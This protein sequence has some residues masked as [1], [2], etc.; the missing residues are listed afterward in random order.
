MMSESVFEELDAR[1]RAAVR[2]GTHRVEAPAV[3]AGPR[4]GL[5]IILRPDPEAA[6][7]LAELANTA[8]DAAGRHHWCTG[9]AASSHITI[10]GLEP[11]RTDIPADDRAV[12]QYTRAIELAA[13][14]A[15]PITFTMGGLILT[16]ISIMVRAQ[17]R[18][19]HAGLLSAELAH[20]L[21]EAGWYEAVFTR[22]IWYLNLVH[23][24][25]PFVDPVSL[26]DWVA[27]RRD[28]DLGT[29]TS[30]AWISCDG[31]SVQAEPRFP[32]ASRQPP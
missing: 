13:P 32:S 8:I 3:D 31:I 12:A 22:T 20:A 16:P 24:A 7:R 26:I 29:T 4:W 11:H 15:R 10:R 18:A 30:T 14:Q 21:G 25:G 19:P 6:T 5:S 1:G 2:S 9:Q 23:F 27:E 17:P 28:L